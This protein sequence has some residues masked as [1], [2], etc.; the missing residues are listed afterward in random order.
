MKSGVELST[1]ST[2]L[3]L[4][5]FQIIEHPVICIFG[6]GMLNLYFNALARNL[7]R[8]RESLIAHWHFCLLG[9]WNVPWL[10]L[11]SDMFEGCIPS[12]C[13]REERTRV[14]HLALVT[15]Y[16]PLWPH[17]SWM[18]LCSTHNSGCLAMAR[19]MKGSGPTVQAKPKGRSIAHTSW[20]S[21]WFSALTRGRNQAS[22]QPVCRKETGLVM[23]LSS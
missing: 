9:W 11:Y 19:Q 21:A 15:S 23:A 14:N 7:P 3:L 12:D 20:H 10:F 2:V 4:T 6:S 17:S 13:G 22:A 8:R 18:V 1:Y 5:N 16:S